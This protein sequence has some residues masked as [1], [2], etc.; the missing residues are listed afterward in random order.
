MRDSPTWV[1]NGI[2]LL[3]KALTIN[4]RINF[5][6]VQYEKNKFKSS[7]LKV[8]SVLFVNFLK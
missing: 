6:E 4:R 2:N 5:C 7:G 1:N 8:D 3:R